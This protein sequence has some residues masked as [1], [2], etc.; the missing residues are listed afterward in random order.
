MGVAGDV[1]ADAVPRTERGGVG[2]ESSD[3]EA[4]APESAGSSPGDGGRS[5]PRLS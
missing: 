5:R 4:T 2:G 3:G 1:G